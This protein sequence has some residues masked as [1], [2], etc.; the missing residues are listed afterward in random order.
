MLLFAFFAVATAAG[1]RPL[2]PRSELEEHTCNCTITAAKL[3]SP[4]MLQAL[5]DA[6]R[7][8]ALDTTAKHS[9]HAQ[10]QGEKPTR[11]LFLMGFL[12]TGTTAVHAMLGEHRNVS[13]L[14]RVTKG[15]DKEGWGQLDWKHREDRWDQRD[16]RFDWK[17]LSHVYHQL[18]NLSKPLLLENSPPEM[19]HAVCRSD[20][21]ALPAPLAQIS[22][23]TA[24]THH[25]ATSRTQDALNETFSRHGKVRFLVLVHS[26]C[27]HDGAVDNL[28]C[29]TEQG[30]RHNSSHSECWTLRAR[31]AL[32]I[33]EAYGDDA[34][35][36][37]YED[38][39]LN[40][41]VALN[42]IEA[43]EPLLLGLRSAVE[44]P[45]PK[46][47]G[48]ERLDGLGSFDGLERDDGY[49]HHVHD[50]SDSVQEYCRT[51]NV[52]RWEEGVQ[53]TTPIL[54]HTMIPEMRDLQQGAA[55]A[56]GYRQVDRCVA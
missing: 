5:R 20:S 55:E 26:L 28:G 38:L 11:Y 3:G 1:G 9:K 16:G 48:A 54:P 36:L 31:D 44:H 39:C 45:P 46:L 7:A 21:R 35:V 50:K 19:H 18:W 17:Q 29:G 51:R 34:L 15:D 47:H 30:A 6:R 22:R 43:W 49:D 13:M 10:R 8:E 37:R 24:S 56:L 32:A 2:L 53:L 23:M 12:Y 25:I 14:K 41:R 4:P 33:K 52:P 40:W 27:A 42:A